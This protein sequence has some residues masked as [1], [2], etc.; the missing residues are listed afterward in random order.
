MDGGEE[1]CVE[2]VKEI[3]FGNDLVEVVF[4]CVSF[5][6]LFLDCLEDEDSLHVGVDA[7]SIVETWEE[8]V[9]ADGAVPILM[10]FVGVVEGLV[11]DVYVCNY[12]QEGFAL[13]AGNLWVSHCGI[14]F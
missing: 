5:E 4:E 10:F 14:E 9:L 11:R 8:V 1:M 3:V 12:A 7:D 6:G 2:F 13:I